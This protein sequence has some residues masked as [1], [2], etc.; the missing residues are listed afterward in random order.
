MS[1][2]T[3]VLT[4]KWGGA[5]GSLDA[6]LSQSSVLDELAERHLEGERCVLV[7][8]GSDDVNRLQERLGTPPEFLTS[9]S[10]Q[11]SRRTDR[12][13]LEAFTMATAWLN[14]RLVE[15]LHLRGVSAFGL[16][17]LDGGLVRGRRK[18]SVRA[19]V[20]GRVRVVRDEWTGRPEQVDGALLHTLLDSGRLPVIAPLIG[21]EA[22][23]LITVDADRLAARVAAAVG[24]RE[25]VIL[26]NVPGLLADVA[27]PA[28]RIASI[29][30][31]DF[32]RAEAA[33]EGRMRKKVLGA[34]E[35]LDAGVARVCLGDASS[36]APL[37]SALA[38]LGTVFGGLV[39]AVAR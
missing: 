19:V 15:A 37:A 14:R 6:D 33:A 7:H 34:R 10:G 36:A 4:V 32:A 35:A 28:S 26:S 18:P 2:D 20:D 8:G 27:D 22:G 39:E 31:A 30:P 9:P 25:L 16:S 38:G 24:S 23:E 1:L 12:Q 17:G 3:P 11:V 29:T 5:A 21:S 13:A